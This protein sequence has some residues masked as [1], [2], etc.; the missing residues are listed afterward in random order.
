MSCRTTIFVRPY[1]SRF[2]RLSFPPRSTPPFRFL[3][4]H[5]WEKPQGPV[6]GRRDGQGRRT[7][8]VTV[9]FFTR[10]LYVPAHTDVLSRQRLFP[11]R[12]TARDACGTGST[13]WCPLPGYPSMA[14][15][16]QVPDPS[17]GPRPLWCG[18]MRA[19]GGIG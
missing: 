2:A 14:G 7:Y 5:G 9:S 12:K 17:P 18:K 16:G 6:R 4:T 11:C 10:L 15:R 13:R 8:V 19:V 1:S 3:H